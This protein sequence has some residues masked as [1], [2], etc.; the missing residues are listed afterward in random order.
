MANMNPQTYA[1]HTRWHPPFHFFVLPVM[2]INFVWAVVDF[3]KAP[4]Q[5]FRL[6]DRGFPGPGC[7]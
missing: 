4:G 7:C 5:K 3:V 2:L 6:V 1:N